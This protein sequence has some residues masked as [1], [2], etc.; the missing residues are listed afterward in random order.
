MVDINDSLRVGSLEFSQLEAVEKTLRTAKAKVTFWGA[1][2][3]EIEDSGLCIKLDAL[4]KMILKL[5]Y[6]CSETD[7]VTKEVRIAG[8]EISDKL[9]GFYK[10]TDKAFEEANFLTRF[11][12]FLREFS[13]SSYTPRFFVEEVMESAFRSYSKDEF[14]K[15]FGGG[16][17]DD[18]F[19]HP[20]SDG[21]YTPP[22][23]ILAKKDA[24]RALEV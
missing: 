3:V 8:I 9:I 23:G 10:S 16:F 1:R 13:F 7:G 22:F 14:L 12:R 24:I 18:L 20:L 2:V 11:F 15:K 6:Q 5:S 17:E 4:A 19:K 21:I